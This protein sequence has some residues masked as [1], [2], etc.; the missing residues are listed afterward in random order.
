[1]PVSATDRT[2][3][4]PSR[5]V[6]SVTVPPAGVNFT[7]LSSRLL[8]DDVQPSRGRPA[9]RAAPRRC[10]ARECEPGLLGAGG[11]RVGGLARDGIEVDGAGSPALASGLDARQ[12]QQVRGQRLEPA[13]LPERAR[14]EAALVVG[15]RLGLGE[16]EVGLQRGERRADLVRGIGDEPA[17]RG[18][19][20]LDALGHR[21]EGLGKLADLVVA[22]DVGARGQ[23]AVGHAVARLGERRRCGREMR[24]EST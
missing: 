22:L 6:P 12:A 13:R 23:I 10:R 24:A 17:Q 7:A 18:H 21:V 16:L 14:D 3:E 19:R 20:R 15:R 4:S 11:H 2:A 8:D 1:M 5:R 9:R